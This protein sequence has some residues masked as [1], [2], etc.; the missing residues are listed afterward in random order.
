MKEKMTLLEVIHKYLLVF[1]LMI[2]VAVMGIMRPD[3]FFTTGFFVNVFLT[4]AIYGIMMCG[5][6]FVVIR[7]G[8][9]LSVAR[10]AAL[11]GTILVKNIM[12]SGMTSG[13]VA[14]GI[15]L[16][17]MISTA[18]G[19]LN[20]LMTEYTGVPAIIVTLATQKIISA[21]NQLYIQSKTLT[22]AQPAAFT[23]IA[24]AKL[25]GVPMC[26]V[27]FLVCVAIAWFVLNQ[28]V[29]GREVYAVGGNARTARFTGIQ[30]RRVG[31][32]CFAISGFTAGLA[33][34]V[35]A[36]FNQQAVYFAANGY[37][38]YVIVALVIGGVSLNGGEG[39]ILG[40]AL[41]AVLLGMI[42]RSLILLGVD[43]VYHDIFRG[44]MIVLAVALDVYTSEMSKNRRG[45]K[46]A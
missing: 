33:G 12:A 38:G 7:G 37:E 43:S 44:L 27:I 26:I 13:S 36:S 4:I 22:L 45:K 24:N 25:F 9:D 16:A 3:M 39:N 14:G 23:A 31:V 29:F 34:I 32:A 42:N 1:L 10:I 18:I 35:L 19:L 17:L 11:S 21:V 15:V 41:G 2:L 30:D 6:I 46:S 28:T 5:T 8:I 40:A 20:G